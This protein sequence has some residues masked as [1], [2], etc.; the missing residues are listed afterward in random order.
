MGVSLNTPQNSAA[1]GFLWPTLRAPG[2]GGSGAACEPTCSAS[3]AVDGEKD[4]ELELL[5]EVLAADSERGVVG[6]ESVSF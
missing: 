3:L 4:E 2:T 5:D 6:I 1:F